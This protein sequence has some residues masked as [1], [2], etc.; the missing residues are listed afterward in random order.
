MNWISTKDKLPDFWEP[1]LVVANGEVQHNVYCIDG[2]PCSHNVFESYH[3]GS[4]EE[5]NIQIK[6]VQYWSYLPAPPMN[7]L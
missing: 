5:L 2:A 3:S 1:V 7:K 4:Y 6:E